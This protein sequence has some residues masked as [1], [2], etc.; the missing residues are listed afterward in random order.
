MSYITRE[1]D[2]MYKG[3]KNLVSINKGLFAFASDFNDEYFANDL[4]WKKI[5]IHY[6]HSGSNQKKIIVLMSDSD[7]GWF[8]ASETARTGSWL[9][10]Q[11]Q[12]FDKDGDM[13]VVPR[14]DMPSPDAFDIITN[15]KIAPSELISLVSGS[16]VTVPSVDNY[17]VGF[18]VK[19]WDDLAFQYLNATI[20]TIVSVSGN[21]ITLDQPITDHQGKTLRLKFPLYA[22]STLKQKSVYQ[23]VGVT[24]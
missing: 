21:V 19:L 11:I 1:K 6:K 8:E 4:N 10:E 23:F 20:F 9:V 7:Q 3:E 17:E 2:S 16:T 14:T 18:K 24:F 15:R 22:D 5:A 13:S 12:V